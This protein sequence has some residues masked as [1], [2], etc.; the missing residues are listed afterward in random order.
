MPLESDERF[1]K[2]LQLHNYD[3]ETAKLRLLSDLGAGTGALTLL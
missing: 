2:Y 1:L 3:L